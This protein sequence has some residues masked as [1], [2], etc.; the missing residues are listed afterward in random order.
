V[1]FWQSIEYWDPVLVFKA[2]D[3]NWSLARGSI[4]L[5]V[6]KVSPYEPML[7]KIRLILYLVSG[8]ISFYPKVNAL[9][10]IMAH[11]LL[12][13]KEIFWKMRSETEH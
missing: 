12:P 13:S 11:F 5:C 1:D 6:L 7:N 10:L 9:K 3:K 2:Q 4:S 8:T